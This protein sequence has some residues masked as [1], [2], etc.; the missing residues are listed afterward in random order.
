[1][2]STGYC[3]WHSWPILNPKDLIRGSGGIRKLRWAAHGKGKRGGLRVIYYWITHRGHLLLLTLYR[4][5]EVSDLTP[6]E[7]R[8]LR[9]LVENLED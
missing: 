2:I 9:A 6:G 3:S 4:K 1:M 5:S 8:A 7:V